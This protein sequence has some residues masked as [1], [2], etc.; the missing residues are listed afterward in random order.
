M[1]KEPDE[2]RSVV[3]RFTQCVPEDISSLMDKGMSRWLNVV[4]FFQCNVKFY[5][6]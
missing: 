1:N 5:I 2:T 3:Y 6:M 4:F